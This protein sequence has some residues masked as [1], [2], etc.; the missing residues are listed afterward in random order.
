ML[1]ACVFF[2]PLPIVPLLT[3]LV[4]L[5]AWTACVFFFLGLFMMTGLSPFVH[6]R[7]AF[8]NEAI[9]ELSDALFCPVRLLNT[10]RS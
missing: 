7:M 4:P 2:N 1:G 10:E 8:T 3:F 9:F 6:L 5:S